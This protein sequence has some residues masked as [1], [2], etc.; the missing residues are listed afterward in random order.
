MS[1]IKRSFVHDYLF[2]LSCGEASVCII[3]PLYLF[4][5]NDLD[6]ATDWF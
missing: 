2:A 3:P 5:N 6:P 1:S 4:G